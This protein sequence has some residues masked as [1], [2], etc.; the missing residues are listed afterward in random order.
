MQLEPTREDLDPLTHSIIGCA[1]KVQRALGNGLLESAYEACLS[2]D[3]GKSGFEVQRQ[4]VLPIEYEG[5]RIDA[6]Y[7]PDLIVNREVIV[8]VKTVPKLL[9]VHQAQLLTYLK[10][11]RL[12]RGLLLN[13]HA[14]PFKS[15][16]KRLIISSNK[17]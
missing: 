6:G 16:I 14:M 13:F 2:F 7:R 15:G 4:Q 11:S 1:M 5:F 17:Q 8:E 10:L 12:W 3:L 9:P